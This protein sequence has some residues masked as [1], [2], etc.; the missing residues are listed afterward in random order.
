MSRIVPIPDQTGGLPVVSAMGTPRAVGTTLGQRLRAR[1][2]VAAQIL[3]ERHAALIDGRLLVE[4]LRARMAPALAAISEHGPT[5]RM[6]L[7]ALAAGA[8]LDIADAALVHAGAGVSAMLA[9]GSPVDQTACVLLHQRHVAADTATLLFAWQVDPVLLPALTLVRRIPS[10]APASLTLTLG[11]LHPL[12]GVSEAGLCVAANPMPVA[13][14][15]PGLPI[16]HLVQAALAAPV[17]SD[18][19][20]RLA[21][22]ARMG[23]AAVHVLGADGARITTEITGERSARLDDP[24]A[25]APRVH[26]A[27]ALADQLHPVCPIPDPSRLELQRLASLA[28]HA[29]ALDP[30]ALAG[31]FGIGPQAMPVAG[32]D[33][34]RT[35]VCAI[36]PARKRMH[37][38]R[39]AAELAA[40]D[41]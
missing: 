14:A 1:L 16:G 37:V 31:W 25:D 29:I 41:L 26:T 21:A 34:A 13:D 2:Q 28:S 5:L 15:A 38:V 7:D 24:R 32:W 22:R 20:A 27:H 33:A 23:G 36:E 6:E 39:G 9:Q 10:H 40:I 11:G 18:A 17:A 35:V 30:A 4:P 12:A 19:V 3:V 8:E